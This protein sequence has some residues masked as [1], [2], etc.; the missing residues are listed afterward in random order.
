MQ[1]GRIE[2]ATALGSGRGEGGHHQGIQS[3]WDF[4]G[5]G[6]LLLIPRTG[7]LSG[8]RQL[9]GGGQELVAGKGGVEEDDENIQQVGG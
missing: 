8:R 2:E 6:D 3:L 1:K 5:D 4:P 7:D 9:T